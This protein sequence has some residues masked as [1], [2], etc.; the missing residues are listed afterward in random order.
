MKNEC[1]DVLKAGFRTLS[2]GEG[3]SLV[4]GC[5]ES[6]FNPEV[7]V[8][9]AKLHKDAVIPKYSKPG[10]AG[11]DLTAISM[12][13]VR[14]DKVDYYEYNFGLAVEIPEGYVGLLFPRSSISNTDLV[15][16]NSVG[17][18]DSGYRGCLTARFRKTTGSPHIYKVGDRVA[19]LVVLPYPRVNIQEVKYEE[20][21]V[22]ERGQGGYGHTGS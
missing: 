1:L 8:K 11:L 14:T 5:L 7:N 3:N 20:L 15:L 22:T 21:S 18:V 6:L 19:Q 9:F 2:H 13:Y 12:E 4:I 17:V 16:S 10:D